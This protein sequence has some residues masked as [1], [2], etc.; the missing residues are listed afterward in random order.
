MYSSTKTF[1]RFHIYVNIA[2]FF[3]PIFVLAVAIKCNETDFVVLISLNEP[4]I[5]RTLF[6]G[7]S[8]IYVQRH[9]VARRM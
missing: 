2:I 6:D 7:Q 3:M 5:G 1:Y 4:K 8:T 9:S